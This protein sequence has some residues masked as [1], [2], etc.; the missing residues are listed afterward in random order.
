MPLIWESPHDS[1]RWENALARE[2]SILVPE[3][4][5][6][7]GSVEAVRGQLNFFAADRI[8]DFAAAHQA[9]LRGHTL[10]WHSQLPSWVPAAFGRE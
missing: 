9:K 5:M 10:I 4:S 8:A 2:C 7:W 1:F 6:K 3:N